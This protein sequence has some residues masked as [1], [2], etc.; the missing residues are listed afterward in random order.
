[1]MRWPYIGGV[2]LGGLMV[3]VALVGGVVTNPA[4]SLRA[5]QYARIDLAFGDPVLIDSPTGPIYT[6]RRGAG[7][8][9]TVLFIHG[10]ADSASGWVDVAGAIA[11]DHAVAL[12]DLP[13]HGRSGLPDETLSLPML[14]AA[15]EAWMADNSDEVI[16]VG[17]SLGG[18]L[19]QRLADRHPE[20]VKKVI[21]LNSGGFPT[22]YD[23]DILLP[24]DREAMRTKNEWIFGTSPPP[25][26]DFVVDGLLEMQ[27]L[28]RYE[29]L[30]VDLISNDYHTDRLLPTLPMPV[31]LI[32]GTPDRF[33]PVKGY[34]DRIQAARPDSALV[35]LDDC[36]HAP[37]YSCPADLTQ[38]LKAELP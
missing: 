27:G 30:Y 20:R 13:G 5:V 11:Q 37:Q 22:T 36:G 6:W 2:V 12:I 26:P 3:G 21:L 25:L 14:E 18:W 29:N 32:W 38:A 15:L 33:F 28:P 8:G 17:N 9:P 19:S 1:M 35:T 16:L 7:D 23:I 24:V 4:D 10:F 31:S 34:L